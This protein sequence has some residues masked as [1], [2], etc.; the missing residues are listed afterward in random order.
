MDLLPWEIK[1]V[2]ITKF[3]VKLV[4]Q[5]GRASTPWHSPWYPHFPQ[6]KPIRYPCKSNWRTLEKEFFKRHNEGSLANTAWV[7]K[8][9]EAHSSSA[10]IIS[11]QGANR[12][13]HISA[14]ATQQRIYIKKKNY[15]IPSYS[16]ASTLCCSIGLEGAV[17]AHS[18]LSCTISLQ[19]NS[20]TF[21]CLLGMYNTVQQAHIEY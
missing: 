20:S 6:C 3:M 12:G 2:K 21:T 17:L 7:G 4:C 10:Y 8:K 15:K 1:R 11:T 13:L 9:T 18:P 19:H 16:S 14:S 5:E